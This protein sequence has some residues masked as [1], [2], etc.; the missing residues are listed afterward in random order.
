MYGSSDDE[1]EILAA[2]DHRARP[3][4]APPSSDAFDNSPNWKSFGRTNGDTDGHMTASQQLLLLS[5]DSAD[6]GDDLLP[7]P[8]RASSQQRPRDVRSTSTTTRRAPFLV[9]ILTGAD[10]RLRHAADLDSQASTSRLQ[11]TPSSLQTTSGPACLP[12]PV[13]PS[14]T[15]TVVYRSRDP[16]A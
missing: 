11:K 2:P 1:I 16:S 15:Q 6:E 7:P 3:S 4:A 10:L 12:S 14:R 5:D 8:F 9:L 13:P